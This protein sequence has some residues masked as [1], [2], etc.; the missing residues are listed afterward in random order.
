VI[1]DPM[2]PSDNSD[3]LMLAR[4]ALAIVGGILASKGL[5]TAEEWQTISGAILAVAP[6]I[7][8][9]VVRRRMKAAIKT[10]ASERVT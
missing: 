4:Y 7:Y 9:I 6:A 10:V 5:A 2:K 1:P 8:G 3:A